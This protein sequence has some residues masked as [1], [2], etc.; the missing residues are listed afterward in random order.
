RLGFRLRGRGKLDLEQVFLLYY[1]ARRR[2]REHHTG[3]NRSVDKDGGQHG[4]GEPGGAP[5]RLVSEVVKH[6]RCSV[7]GVAPARDD[8]E[9]GWRNLGAT[10]VTAGRRG[11]VSIAAQSVS[12]APHRLYQVALAAKLAA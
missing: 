6:L 2:T 7:A 12:N 5:L 4:D 3:A 1:S 9:T 11:P 8:H 10:L